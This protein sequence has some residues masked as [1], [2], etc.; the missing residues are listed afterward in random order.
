MS[1]VQSRE[2]NGLGLA[3]VHSLCQELHRQGIAYCH[4]KSNEHLL[5]GM[6]GLTD[7][8][9]LVER[10][11]TQAL[12]QALSTVGCKR[13]SAVVGNGYPA[14]EDYL[15]LDADTGTLIHLHLHYQLV[16]GEP[17]LKGYR[18]PWEQQVLA[19]RVYR[20]EEQIYTA[21]PHMEMLLLV[22]R[23][24]L[25]MRSRDRLFDNIGR[26]FFGGERL[27]EYHWLQERTDAEKTLQLAASIF[28][29]QVSS[30]FAKLLATAKP[31]LSQLRAVRRSA[32]PT[33]RLYRT[34]SPLQAR[35]RRS[36]N[37]IRWL[38][39]GLNKRY[40][41]APLPMRRVSA[42]G[43]LLIALLGCDGSGKSTHL[44]TV[45]RWLGWKLDVIPIYFGSGDGSVSLLRWPM[46]L[47]ADALRKS[48]NYRSSR[49]QLASADNSSENTKRNENNAATQPPPTRVRLLA[50]AL[51]ALTLSLEKRSKLR[52]AT[53]ARNRG[54]VVICDRYPQNQVMGFNDGPLLSAWQQHSSRLLRALANWERQAYRAA[55]LYPPDLVVKLNLSADVAVQRK[56]EMDVD[57][58]RRR[59]AVIEGLAYPASMRV[60]T[61]DATK[62]LETVLLN[63]KKGIWANF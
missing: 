5:E 51:W 53:A 40:V 50:K 38:L 30:V 46:K 21:D 58:C 6:R 37:E 61:L 49:Y 57:E 41:H 32:Y 59:I 12:A 1:Q 10:G 36:F 44:Y 62:P 43:G 52:K 16:A 23:L 4:F 14:V 25:K 33:L 8:D 34:Y 47:V 55:E 18:L 11:S 20:A 35:L 60:M 27:R 42:S 24:A 15:A 26:R 22:I 56:P 17:H 54:M 31:T 48:P 28:G 63:L 2:V 3:V 39:G 45:R 7:L 13:F 9:M 19:T 29:E